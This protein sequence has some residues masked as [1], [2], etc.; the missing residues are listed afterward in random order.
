[1]ATTAARRWRTVFAEV[2]DHQQQIGLADDRAHPGVAGLLG[3]RR[4]V[5]ELDAHVL[6]EHHGRLGEL[7]G[8]WVRRDLRRGVGQGGQEPGLAGV[9]RPDERDLAGALLADRVELGRGRAAAL[10]LGL[11]AQLRDAGAQV[12]LEVVGALVLGHDRQHGLQ[13]LDLLGGRAGPPIG[14]LGLVVRRWQVRGHRRLD[15]AAYRQF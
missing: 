10:L 8:E 2:D 3:D 13:R 9:G 15:P 4:Q 6:V 11:V 5:D 7:G 14:L 1:L 12:G